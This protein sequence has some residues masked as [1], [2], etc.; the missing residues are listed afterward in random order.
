MA[1]RSVR[2][3]TVDDADTL[4]ALRVAMY[5]ALEVDTS[6]SDWRDA[7]RSLLVERLARDDFAGMLCEVGGEAVSGGVAWV[8]FHLPNPL[9]AAGRRGYISSMS[10]L[11]HARGRGHARA[12]VQALLDWCV[13]QGCRRVDLR[14]TTYGE[15]LYSGMGFRIATGLPMTWTTP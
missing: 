13:A 11:P 2:R 15:P 9:D 5:D 8:E 3:A 1:S 6:G 7:C 14:A 12:V 10:T 4:L